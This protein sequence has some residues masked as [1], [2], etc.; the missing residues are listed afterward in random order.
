MIWWYHYFRKPPYQIIQLESHLQAVLVFET[1]WE[2]LPQ[3]LMP[4]SQLRC[5]YTHHQGT[6]KDD[7][8][9]LRATA[10]W[11]NTISSR[12]YGCFQKQC[13]PEIIHF[14]KLFH[15]IYHPFWG[16]SLFW[17]IPW[18]FSINTWN[19]N[20]QTL[21]V[22]HR[23]IERDCSHY[24]LQKFPQPDVAVFCFSNNP[25]FPGK[26]CATPFCSVCQN[27]TSWWK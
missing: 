18:C 10:K 16:V 20:Y 19:A 6:Q 4:P 7:H 27:V 24:G 2:F 12:R 15:Y 26:C 3:F 9:C 22:P 11:W 25:A 21:K 8:R 14:N 1:T 17:E 23:H 5:L 13:Y